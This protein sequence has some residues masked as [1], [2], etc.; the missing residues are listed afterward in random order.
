ML[1]LA[2][3][4]LSSLNL[5]FDNILE[6]YTE[7]V[8]LNLDPKILR[9]DLELF[10]VAPRNGFFLLSQSIPS[11]FDGL[12]NENLVLK[13]GHSPL[14]RGC[15]WFHFLMYGFLKRVIHMAV[16]SIFII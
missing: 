8:P 3:R 4:E 12:N 11:I 15:V 1:H 6:S 13:K 9:K 10:E 5:D 7:K 16:N 14:K 2:L